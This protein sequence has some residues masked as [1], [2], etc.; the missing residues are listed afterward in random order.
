VRVKFCPKLLI[1]FRTL[2]LGLK[3]S[4]ITWA[5]AGDFFIQHLIFWSDLV[6]F[7]R[8]Y[9]DKLHGDPP[10]GP[11]GPPYHGGSGSGVM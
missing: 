7:G 8:I 10:G 9:W 1:G 4:G 3:Q 6:G 2:D 11:A 5:V